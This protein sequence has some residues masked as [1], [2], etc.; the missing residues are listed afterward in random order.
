M[1]NFAANPPHPPSN[2]NNPFHRGRWTYENPVPEENPYPVEQDAHLHFQLGFTYALYEAEPS[3]NE[4]LNDGRCALCRNIPDAYDKQIPLCPKC[5]DTLELL[6][7]FSYDT[8]R[9]NLPIARGMAQARHA[10]TKEVAHVADDSI[11][12]SKPLEGSTEPRSEGSEGLG[13]LQREP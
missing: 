4:F 3:K 11:P 13:P 5:T 9:S 8:L 7:H 1:S 2:S 6:R 10:I 12:S